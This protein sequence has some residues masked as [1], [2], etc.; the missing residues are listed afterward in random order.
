MFG[1]LFVAYAV[2]RYIRP[3]V[4]MYAHKS[5]NTNLGLINTII[6]LASSLTMALAIWAI[7]KGN[8]K[9]A[10]AMLLATLAGGFGFLGV[11]SV[12][13]YEKLSKGVFVG[14]NNIYSPL[15]E[16]GVH[17]DDHD[18]EEHADTEVEP[19]PSAPANPTEFSAGGQDGENIGDELTQAEQR[20]ANNPIEAQPRPDLSPLGRQYVDPHAGTG[21]AIVI[22]PQYDSVD[23]RTVD[24]VRTGS[25]EFAG[26]HN[27]PTAI[28]NE[29]SALPETPIQA[30][31]HGDADH[32]GYHGTNYEDLSNKDKNNVATFYGIYY[33]MTGLHLVHVLIGMGL[34][35]WVTVK[36]IGGVFSPSYFTPLDLTGL[37]WHLVDLV[38]IFL[39]PLLYLIH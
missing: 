5:L 27:K 1:G 13:Y 2:Y 17:G 23:S 39:F 20:E 9:L 15:S 16:T 3:D 7:Q 12:E 8:Q 14:A 18:D 22:K 29:L 25:G 24:P 21:D 34:I 28:Y 6:L 33:A 11:K 32:G 37:Y 36:T 4:F 26:N 10:V 31:T 35:G 19:A 30:A 38:W